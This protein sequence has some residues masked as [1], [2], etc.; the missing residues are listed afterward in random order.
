MGAVA[1]APNR[2]NARSQ[3]GVVAEHLAGETDQGDGVPPIPQTVENRPAPL[4][5]LTAVT[6]P[7]ASLL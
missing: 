4:G 1:A 5:S 3:G 2:S 6:G 7:G